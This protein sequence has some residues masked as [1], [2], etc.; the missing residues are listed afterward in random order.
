MSNTNYMNGYRQ[1][2][3][4]SK[5]FRDAGY[6]ACRSAGSHSKRDVFVWREVSDPPPK[7]FFVNVLANL[8]YESVAPNRYERQSKKYIDTLFSYRFAVKMPD[9]ECM[10]MYQ[11][12]RK[13]K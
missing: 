5:A 4:L 12:K 8:G 2:Q 11:C 10:S 6:N 13:K 9:H 3:E 7:E 1:E